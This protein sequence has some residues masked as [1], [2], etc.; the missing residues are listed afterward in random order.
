M[1]VLLVA[2]DQT[3]RVNGV[4]EEVTGDY[5]NS[6]VVSVTLK[7]M[8]GTEVAGETWPIILDYVPASNGDYLGNIED[9]IQLKHMKRYY[10]D[11]SIDA[12]LDR[13]AFFHF[14]RYA[15]YRTA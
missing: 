6:A 13:K 8:D 4:Q 11:I 3:I 5:L 14:I 15:K 10:V 7:N 12:G 2:N 1:D 9:G